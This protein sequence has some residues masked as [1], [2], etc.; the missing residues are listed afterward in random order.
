[1]PLGSGAGGWLSG[2]VIGAVPSDPALGGGGTEGTLGA[3]I[4]S[5]VGID[6]GDLRGGTV[7]GGTV[8]GAGVVGA[9]VAP[10]RLGTAGSLGVTVEIAGGWRLGMVGPGEGLLGGRAMGGAGIRLGRGATL[11]PDVLGAWAIAVPE[12]SGNWGRGGTQ[13]VGGKRARRSPKPAEMEPKPASGK[14]VWGR[15]GR[16]VVKA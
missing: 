15:V 13:V 9:G 3:G 12:L 10:G 11:P 2:G 5:G 4:G 1:M 7:G 6:G 14:G 8:G 16:D